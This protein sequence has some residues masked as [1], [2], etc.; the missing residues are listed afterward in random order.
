MNLLYLTTN[1]RTLTL[2]FVA[3]EVTQ[4]RAR[5]HRVELLALRPDAP[6]VADAAECDVSGCIHLLPAPWTRVVVGLSRCLLRRPRRLLKAM[7]AALCSP[8]DSL[9]TR[10]K[11]LYQVAVTTTVVERVENLGVSHIHAHLA[12][13]PGNYAWFLS[14]LTGIPF[15]FTGHAA[16]LFCRPEALRAKLH[17]AAGVIGISEHNLGYLRSLVPELRHAAVIHCGIDAC[18]FPY[19]PRKAAGS[20]PRILAVGRAVPK[21]GLVFLV[22]ALR[23]LGDRGQVWRAD[24]VGDGPLLETLRNEAKA[25]KLDALS[26]RG[27]LQQHEIRELL[28]NADVFVLPCVQAP[29]GDVDGIPVALMEAMAS[30][31]PVISTRISGIPELVKDGHSGLL[32]GPADPLSLADAL[33][34]LVSEPGLGERLS[35]GGREAIEREFDLVTIGAQLERFFI[36]IGM[37]AD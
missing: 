1:F 28:A 17:A 2:T 11:M 18:R 21:K 19:R 3:R 32:V 20:P 15:S 22:R 12:S 5:G 29:D 37:P 8:G 6:H 36:S 16:D 34:R 35:R 25:L 10:L 23:L 33:E 31:V 27:A 9:A 26:F 4:L 7:S 30:G 24:I 13:P 14:L